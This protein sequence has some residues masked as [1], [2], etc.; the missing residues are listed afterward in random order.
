LYGAASIGLGNLN[1]NS[2]HRAELKKFLP[3]ETLL[4]EV[5]GLSLS[6]I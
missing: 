6:A 5:A 3:E 2:R 1:S 4:L